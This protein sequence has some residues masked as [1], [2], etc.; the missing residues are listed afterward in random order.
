MIEIRP[1]PTPEQREAILRALAA[2][3]ERAEQASAWWQAGIRD[4]VEGDR[5]DADVD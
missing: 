1:E 2:L 4:A 5:E 3:D